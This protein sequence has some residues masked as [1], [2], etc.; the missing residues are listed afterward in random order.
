[1]GLIVGLLTFPLAPVRGTVWI[2]ERLLEQ[3]E[4][5]YYDEGEI[6]R[7]LIEIEAQREAG[8]LTDEEAERAE[9]ELVERLI[10]GQARGVDENH[11]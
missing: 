4:E 9:D 3:A 7:L 10:E 11:G 5:Q 8:R 2:A 6:Q 1:M